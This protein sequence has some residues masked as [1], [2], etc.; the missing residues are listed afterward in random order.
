MSERVVS[1]RVEAIDPAGRTAAWQSSGTTPQEVALDFVRRGYTPLQVRAQDQDPLAWLH[2]PLGAS[3]G[4]GPAVLARLAEQLAEMLDAGLTLEAALDILQRARAGHGRDL[5]ARLLQRVRAGQTLS[6]A[7]GDEAVAGPVC[8]LVRAAEESG[9]LGPAFAELARTLQR[10]AATRSRVLQALTYPVLVLA[11]LIV[12]LGFVLAYVVPEIAAVF[13]AGDPRLPWLTRVV[14]VASD[15]V[16]HR[17]AALLGVLSGSLLAV[18]A[19]AARARRP[20]IVRDLALRLPFVSAFVG[21]QSARTLGVL[22]AM[23]AGGVEVTA[24]LAQAADTAGGQAQVQ[25][26]QRAAAAVRAGSGVTPALAE[27]LHL[28]EPTL[29]MIAIGEQGGR[30]GRMLTRASRLLELECEERIARF[31]SLINP[32]SVALMGLLVGATVAGVMAGIVGINQLA[33]R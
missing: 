16:V 28:P 1:F 2:R 21:L 19:V 30:L 15:L 13:D 5:A 25:A 7:L 26:L 20:G 8:G 18:A 6:D 24:A 3:A 10:Q 29:A 23:V 14:L 22:G 4:P 27:H 12:V 32:L 17:P 11:L 9:E 31:V 33:V